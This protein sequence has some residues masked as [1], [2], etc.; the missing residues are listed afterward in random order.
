MLSRLLFGIYVFYCFEVG[1]FLV[2]FPWM[3][4]WRENALLF[5]FPIIRPVV[6]NDYFRGAVTG[7][8]I[9]N[10]ILGVTEIIAYFTRPRPARS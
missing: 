3:D 8:G 5:Y 7:L 10:L 1:V 6:L 2:I 9:A 4:Y